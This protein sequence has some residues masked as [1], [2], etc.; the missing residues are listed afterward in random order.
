MAEEEKIVDIRL[1]LKGKAKE[2]FLQIKAAKGLVNNTDVCRLIINEYFERNLQ[3][4][5]A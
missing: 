3:K 1:R 5:E 4:K 2:H